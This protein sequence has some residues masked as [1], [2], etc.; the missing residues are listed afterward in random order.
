MERVC[1]VILFLALM[2]IPC[3][4][5]WTIGSRSFTSSST[6]QGTAVVGLTIENGTDANTNLPL[7]DPFVTGQGTWTAGPCYY[8][9]NDATSHTITCGLYS[10]STGAAAT[11]L[12]SV[13]ATGTW[14]AGTFNLIGTPTG[15]P[16]LSGATLYYL[17][18]ISSST[19]PQDIGDN[20]GAGNANCPAAYYS[21]A[22]IRAVYGST[23]GS[24][25]LPS[26]FG[27]NNDYGACAAQYMVLNCVS[28][29]TT[30]VLGASSA[31]LVMPSGTNGTAVSTTTLATDTA[32]TDGDWGG[33]LTSMVYSNAQSIAYHNTQ[34][35]CGV[36][37]TGATGIS[38]A[39][40]IP[41]GDY[42]RY[43]PRSQYWDTQQGGVFIFQSG[44]TMVSGDVCDVYEVEGASNQILMQIG[45]DSTQYY[46][47]METTPSTV[48]SGSIPTPQG[49]WYWVGMSNASTGN[50]QLAVYETTGWTQIGSTV[51]SASQGPN[52]NSGSGV[53][54]RYGNGGSCSSTAGTIYYGPAVQEVDPAVSFPFVAKLA[55]PELRIPV[56]SEEDV[57]WNKNV[58]AQ[59]GM[60]A[61]GP[62]NLTR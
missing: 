19:N 57:A 61:D 46:M 59:H 27:T 47:K 52:W 34:T 24:T 29:C 60:C 9:T 6:V 25:T 28:G 7:A 30:P 12:C 8:W 4:A 40:T 45:H 18:T 58:M 1:K 62:C 55:I 43:I 2:L 13:S 33:S 49:A 22:R 41:S 51:T 44:A 50:N 37:H 56:K 54:Y 26:S 16:N 3:D 21:G 39:R 42:W 17:A 36:S 11:L 20:Y 5:Q 48:G 10:S 15:C 23:Q 31:S 32:C 53:A 14:T 38:I 35:A